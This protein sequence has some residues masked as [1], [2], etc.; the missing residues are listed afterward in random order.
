VFDSPELSPTFSNSFSSSA[1][2]Y[3]LAVTSSLSV[4]NCSLIDSAI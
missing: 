4:T 1:S 3:S 2:S